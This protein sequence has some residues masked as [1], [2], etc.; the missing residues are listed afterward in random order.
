MNK[1]IIENIIFDLDGVLV[2]ACEWHYESLNKA[3][4]KNGFEPISLTNHKK[5]FNGLPTKVKLKILGLNPKE[6]DKVFADKQHLTNEVIHE[7]CVHDTAKMDFLFSLKNRG[8]KIGCVTNSIRKTALS[9]LSNSGIIDFIDITISN[10][11]VTVP[12][13]NQEGYIKCMR[14]FLAKPSNTIIVEDSENGI[15]AA[16]KTGC[17][18]WVVKNA[19]NVNEDGLDLF[20]SLSGV[21]LKNG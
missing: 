4:I 16:N 11:D 21:V 8:L 5:T 14:L 6:I 2:D 9:M 7:L 20:C 13:P 15:S 12:K 1:P 10:E 19:T 17:F 3:L 18:V